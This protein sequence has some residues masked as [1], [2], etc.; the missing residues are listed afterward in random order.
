MLVVHRPDELVILR[1]NPFYFKVDANGQQLPYFNEMHFRLSTWGDRTT[2]TVAGTGDFSNMEDPANYV[3]ALRQS[4]SEDSPVRAAFGPR[5]LGWRIDLN[6]DVDNAPDDYGKALRA[7]FRETD[8]RKALSHGLDRDAIGQ[9]VTRGPFAHPYTGG[10]QTGSPYFDA[11]STA[12]Q[13]F[14]QAKA[15]ALL[16]GLGL[17]DTDGNG[18]RNLPDGDDIVIDVQFKTQRNEDRKQLDAAASQLAE[19]GI[20]LQ[21][22]GI[23]ETNFDTVANGGTFDAKVERINFILPTF[24]T[25]RSLPAGDACPL[26]NQSG[27]RM[28]FE[29]EIAAAYDAFVASGDAGEKAEAARTIQN[30]ITENVYSVGLVQFPAALLINK[31]VRNAHPGTPVF[32]Y[33]WAEDAVIRERLWTAADSQETELL[34]GTIAEY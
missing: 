9:A 23:D 12:Y 7:L 10:F 29:A 11:E 17:T 31:R 30:L 24:E 4:Q 18:V 15:N 33:E 16:D 1:R 5:V 2:Q 6:Y 26:F 3:E 19:I 13:A 14:D 27:D 32:M 21:P 22:R 8:F 34:P 25:C 20:R 28:P